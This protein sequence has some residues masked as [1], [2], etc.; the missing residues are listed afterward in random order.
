MYKKIIATVGLVLL[1]GILS[2][3][4]LDLNRSNESTNLEVTT[5]ASV[6]DAPEGLKEGNQAP[7]FELETLSGETIRLSDLRGKK[8]FLNF[9]ATWCPPC[10]E[11]MPE[12]QTFYEKYQDE[13]EIVAVNLTWSEAKD[14]DV[15][16][17]IDEYNYTYPIL[18]DKKE[19]NS[20]SNDLYS[21][22]TI[23]TTYFIGT[24]GVI[25]QPRKIGPMTQSFM[26]E[27]MNALD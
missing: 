5:E 18:L 15:K 6:L 17:F 12:M 25:Q 21:A 11:E 26:E 13:V 2:Y 1:L 14:S 3:N 23:P 16:E 20:V 22:I 24:D 10:K 4:V 7:D 8:V 27:M 19:E 9:W